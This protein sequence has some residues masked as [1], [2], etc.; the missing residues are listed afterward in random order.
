MS[1]LRLHRTVLLLGT[2]SFFNDLSSEMIYPMLPAFLATTLGAGALHL[3]LIEGFAEST[4]AFIKVFSGMWADRLKH[5]KPFIF[6][7][8]GLAG[9]SRSMIGLAQAWPVIW[10]LRFFDRLGKG[11]RTS[12]RDALIADVTPDDH[13]GRAYGLHRAMDHAGAVVGPLVAAALLFWGGLTVRQVFLSAAAPAVFVMVFLFLIRKESSPLPLPAPEERPAAQGVSLTSDFKLFLMAVFLFELGGSTDAFLLLRLADVGVPPPM[14]A[15]L[16]S[17]LHIVKMSTTYLL[18][19]LADRVNRRH[20]L[21]GGWGL[22]ALIYLGIGSTSSQIM[23][24]VLFLLYGLYFGLTEPAERALISH[25][26]TTRNR[27]TLFGYYHGTVGLAALPAGLLFGFLWKTGGPAL[28]FYVAA[29]LST[30]ACILLLLTVR[31][32]PRR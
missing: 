17:M 9:I 2:A 8:Y 30:M 10:A 14:V 23:T 15:I 27:G 22:Y 26:A 32:G 19:P 7:G 11:V 21:A 25:W 31:Y 18:G 3:G 29:G 6:V 4:A 16:W 28:S 20:L 24:V 1:A 12:P 13:R 5:R